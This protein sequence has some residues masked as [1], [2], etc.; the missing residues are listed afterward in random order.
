MD[1]ST[2]DERLLER[3]RGLGLPAAKEKNP[4]VVLSVRGDGKRAPEKWNAKVYRNKEGRLR[5]VTVD[6]RTLQDMLEGKGHAKKRV[7]QVDDA[8]WGFPLGGVM[9]GAT[10]GVRVETAMVP[11]EYFQGE[12]FRLKGYL[13]QAADATLGLLRRLDARPE[14]T[15]VEICTGYVNVGSKE[16]LRRAGYDVRVA[17]I[18]GLLQEELE[19]RFAEY[20]RGLGY[21]GY[22]DPKETHDSRGKFE[23]IMRWVR[24]APEERMKLAKT[25]WGRLRLKGAHG[26]NKMG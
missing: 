10:D 18:A 1:V 15:T 25:G 21:T 9:I 4:Y 11:V 6:L 5:L 20:V 23:D 3:I 16:A 19:R 17:E 24:E 22:L 2:I 12:R 8:G 13:R 26:A 14:D 7:V